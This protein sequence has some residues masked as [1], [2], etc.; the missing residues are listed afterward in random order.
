MGISRGGCRQNPLLSVRGS[1]MTSKRMPRERMAIS[2]AL[3]MMHFFCW[4]NDRRQQR[5]TERRLS[6]HVSVSQK[7][8]RCKCRQQE[9]PTHATLLRR[10]ASKRL[11]SRRHPYKIKTC[12]AKCMRRK[13]NANMRQGS[14]TQNTA[15]RSHA[16]R[17]ANGI[18]CTRARLAMKDGIHLRVAVDAA[19]T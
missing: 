11:G 8:L 10:G 17:P 5:T 15:T 19:S 1:K 12:M 9:S 2:S 4:E 6:S 7:P 14:D 3:G 16:Q 13:R 18:T